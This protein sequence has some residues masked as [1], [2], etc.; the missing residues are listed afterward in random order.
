MVFAWRNNMKKL[1]VVAIILVCSI[2]PAFAEG[3]I[4]VSLTPEW[5]GVGNNNS[6]IPN[7]LLTVDG[8]NY[9]SEAYGI[10]VEYGFGMSFPLNT[11]DTTV[12]FVF[13]VGVGYRYEFFDFLGV[14]AGLGLSSGYLSEGS[15]SE[16]DLAVYGRV[17][18]DFTF[19]DVIRVNVGLAIGGP[20]YTEPS[21][22]TK[23]GGIFLAPFVGVSY[24]Y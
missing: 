19:I 24:V 23:D 5:T 14:V 8:A 22:A 7:F 21:S 15:S 4:G 10:G 12:G 17:A 18:A 3:Q 11:D 2:I 9:F 6:G 16:F 20:F 13:R 1:F